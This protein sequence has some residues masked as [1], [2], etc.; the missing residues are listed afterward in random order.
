MDEPF[1]QLDAQ[2]RILMET[3]I[4]RVYGKKKKR[5]ILFVTSNID[6]A[7]Y[8]A[9]R[10]IVLICKLPS[11]LADEYVIDL[12]RPRNLTGHDFLNC[13]RRLQTP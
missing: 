3:E 9:D 5:T 1:G 2:T 6:E 7:I 10:I 11:H 8:L 13:V 4:E 12:P